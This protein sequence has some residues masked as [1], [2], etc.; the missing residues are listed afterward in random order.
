MQ[1]PILPQHLSNLDE[2]GLQQHA[3]GHD[4][5]APAAASLMVYFMEKGKEVD[6][7]VHRKI[8]AE[9]HGRAHANPSGYSSECCSFRSILNT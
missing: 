9:A 1:E 4:D 2:F 8:L 7:E 5:A 6:L 3:T